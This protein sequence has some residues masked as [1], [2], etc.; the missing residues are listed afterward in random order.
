[1]PRNASPPLTTDGV[2]K[3]YRQLAEIHIIPT[4]QLAECAHWLWYDSTLSTIRARTGLLR[5]IETPS[6]IR[7]A[8]SPLLISCP[9]LGQCGRISVASPK[10]NRV[11][12]ACCLS[13]ACGA[14]GKVDISTSSRTRSRSY[15]T[16]PPRTLLVTRR[17]SSSLHRE[18]GW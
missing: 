7:L 6:T 9:R 16:S 8:P 10:C 15:A 2:D 3:M 1:M 13:A 11:V 17:S 18:V 4:A 14:R 12:R 5:T